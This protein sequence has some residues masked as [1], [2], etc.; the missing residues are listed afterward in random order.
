MAKELILEHEGKLNFGDY[1][2]S[3]K[4]KLDGFE[5]HGNI[6]KVKTFRELTKLERDGMFV[7]ESE[8]GTNVSDFAQTKDGLSFTVT[9]FEDAMITVGLQE[10]TSYEVTVGNGAPSLMKTNL[11]GKLSFS[12]PLAEGESVAVSMKE[13]NG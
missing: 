10:D 6:Y 8:P 4:G 11:G 5:C 2:L 9:G 3:E 12:V 13:K 7:Y 1:A